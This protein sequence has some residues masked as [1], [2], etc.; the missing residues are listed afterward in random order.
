MRPIPTRDATHVFTKPQTWGTE[1]TDGV[2]GDL[3]V[4]VQRYNGGER[5]ECVST[6]QPSPDELAL[7]NKGGVV[8]LS[9]IGKQVPVAIN[10]EPFDLPIADT[11]TAAPDEDHLDREGP[12]DV[13]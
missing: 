3:S 6:W 10:V 4:R 1:T 13:V 9:I 7:L 2:C 12:A 11:S 5:M 8:L